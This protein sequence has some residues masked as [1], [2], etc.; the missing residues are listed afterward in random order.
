M[1]WTTFQTHNED[2]RK[3]FEVLCNQ[4]FEKWVKEEYTTNIESFHYVNGSGGDGGVESYATLKNKDVIGLQAKWFPESIDSSRIAQIRGSITTALKV[5]PSIV[6]YIVCVPRD[7]ASKTN[8]GA[9]KDAVSETSR[10]ES[11][12]GEFSTIEIELWN[13][14]HLLAELQKESSAGIYRYWFEKSEI[15]KESI[16]FSFEKSKSSWLDTRYVP[17]LNTFGLIHSYVCRFL[18]T[19]ELHEELSRTTAHILELVQSA[20]RSIKE[21]TGLTGLCQEEFIDNISNLEQSLSSVCNAYEKVQLWTKCESAPGFA[22][23]R[24]T[25]LTNFSSQVRKI[26][27]SKD[28][29][30]QYFKMMPLMSA[31]EELNNINKSEIVKLL[32]FA[33]E[34]NPLIFLGEPGTGKTHGIAAVVEELLHRGY[35]VPIL[36]QARDIP[37]E[38]NWGNIIQHTIG[39]SNSWSESEIWQGL[40][41]LADRN[42]SAQLEKSKEIHYEPKVFVVVDGIDEA[43]TYRKWIERVKESSAISKSYLQIK[44]CFLSRPFV[45]KNQKTGARTVQLGASGD[46]SARVLFDSYMQHYNIDVS[47]HAWIKNAITTPLALKLFCD[48]NRDKKITYTSKMD[49]SITKLLRQKIGLM[50]KEY[51][52]RYPSATLEDQYVLRAINALTE[53]F[54]GQPRCERKYVIKMLSTELEIEDARNLLNYLTSYGLLRE[55]G[56]QNEGSLSQTIYYYYPGIQGYFDYAE[57]VLLLEKYKSPEKINFGECLAIPQN[58]LYMLAVISIQNFKYLLTSNQTLEQLSVPH[59]IEDLYYFSLRQTSYETAGLFVPDLK[60]SLRKSADDV[61]KIT[62]KIVLPLAQDTHHP[63]GVSLLDEFLDG[64]DSPAE[65]DMYWSIPSLNYYGEELWVTEEELLLGKEDYIL[66]KTDTAEGLPIVYV[67]ALSTVDNR[68]RRVYRTD[69]MKWSLEVPDEFF[70]LF[71]KFALVNDPQIKNDIFSI[72]MSLLFTCRNQA[73]LKKAA[74]W[75]LR[76]ILS[77]ENISQNRDIAIRYYATSILRKAV[78]L[79]LIREDTAEQYLPPYAEMLFDIDLNKEALEGER[80]GGYGPITYDLSRYVLID[81][82]ESCFNANYG[83]GRQCMQ[84]LL[85]IIGAKNT[86]FKDVSLSQF[87]LSAAYS[88]I[89]KCGWDEEKF[90]ICRDRPNSTMGVDNAILYTYPSETHG[91]QSPVMTV[92][93]KYVWQARKY[94]LGFLS[95]CVMVSDENAD[96]LKYIV[97]YGMFEKFLMPTLEFNQGEKALDKN[98]PWHI[99]NCS[100]VILEESVS[101]KESLIG[102]IEKAPDI[103]WTEWLHCDNGQR[104]Y[105]IEEDDLIILHD[106][107]SVESPSGIETN[108]WINAILV[109]SDDCHRFIKEIS[110]LRKEAVEALNPNKWCG[111]YICD[112]YISPNEICWMPWKERYKD[113]LAMCFPDCNIL[114]AVDSCTYNYGDTGDASFVLPALPIREHLSICNTD[115]NNFYN[116]DNTIVALTTSVGIPWENRQVE[117]L[118]GKSLLKH[119]EKEGYSLVWIMRED[120]RETLRMRELYGDFYAEKDKSYVAYYSQGEIIVQPIEMKTQE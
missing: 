37:Q 34:T 82:I 20:L 79:N 9:N 78:E 95:D 23:E 69:L 5:R 51:C 57:A 4:L 61:H 120:R 100:N 62:N 80:M 76:N 12:V 103:D 10:W 111:G 49:V 77:R 92:A 83:T 67:W 72:L 43:P 109:S 2:P 28:Y 42:K 47:N 7:L 64:F 44:F 29:Q 46:V 88:F 24:S 16:E 54:S 6:K 68:R 1:N 87:I 116:E 98:Y 3:A 26:T 38:W 75:M 25:L 97:D 53:L 106:F 33:T 45:F 114:A 74:Y 94:I 105:P 107:S 22:Y 19:D 36:V 21:L 81:H 99:P 63:L 56:E 59:F 110:S 40:I 86:D 18:E 39:L 89:L 102:L 50:E 85:Y 104:I 115:G 65:R 112:C 119:L 70:K 66:S 84:E 17:E 55:Y 118:V 96:V 91:V 31:L 30:S 113:E 13:E 60:K 32:D 93:E 117:M 15:T 27:T 52:N 90:Y 101:S 11:L 48:I 41:S 108:L 71:K 73:L 35:H 58:T 8:K 14:S